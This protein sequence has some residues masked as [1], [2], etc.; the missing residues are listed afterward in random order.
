MSSVNYN[1]EFTL[2]TV[3]IMFQI[4]QCI[5][6]IEH[7][8]VVLTL[9]IKSTVYRIELLSLLTLVSITKTVIKDTFEM[10]S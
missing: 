6:H 8:Y 3:Y 9:A 2:I 5:P 1:C 10:S 4:I 7:N